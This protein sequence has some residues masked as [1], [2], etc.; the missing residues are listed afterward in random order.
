MGALAVPLILAGT[1]VAAAGAIQSGRVARAT[2]E[3]AQRIANYNAA[4]QQQQ[5]KATRRR[6]TIAQRRQAE[7]A[8]RIKSTLLSKI[9]AAYASTLRKRYHSA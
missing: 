5:A 7:R 8:A 4:V 9:G 3:N 6:A 1:G 2:G